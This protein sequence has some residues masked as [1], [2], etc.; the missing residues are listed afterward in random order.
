MYSRPFNNVDLLVYIDDVLVPYLSSV[1]CE[2]VMKVESESPIQL[3]TAAHRIT[4]VFPLFYNFKNVD[5]RA[6]NI[7]TVKVYTPL[8]KSTYSNCQVLST[9]MVV[10]KKQQYHKVVIIAQSR[11]DKR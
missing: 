10:E 1:K 2:Q 5:F 9:E 6:I 3:N 4:L 7:F 8:A 11:T